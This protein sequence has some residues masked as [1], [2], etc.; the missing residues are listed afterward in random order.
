MENWVAKEDGKRGMES[1]FGFLD[2]I[3][4]IS[5]VAESQCPW[6]AWLAP[7]QLPPTQLAPTDP[8]VT[9]LIGKAMRKLDRRHF[10]SLLSTDGRLRASCLLLSYVILVLMIQHHR[11]WWMMSHFV[12]TK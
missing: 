6:T 4:C 3:Q 11:G 2:P 9:V 1:C 7:A 10:S 5:G 12:F 8:V